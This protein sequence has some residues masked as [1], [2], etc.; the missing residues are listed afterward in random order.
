MPTS[1]YAPV[2]LGQG[3]VLL[4]NERSGGQMVTAQRVA[5][6]LPGCTAFRTLEGHARAICATSPELNDPA[7]VVGA[8]QMLRDA[9]VLT[10][11]DSICRRL[12]G[13]SAGTAAVAP[14]RVFVITC[15][16]P[17]AVERLLDSMLRAGNLSSHEELFLVDDSRDGERAER[18]RSA[19]ENFNLTSSREIRYFGRPQQEAFVQALVEELPEHERGIRFLVDAAEW[20]D[21]W[22]A[23]LARTLCILLSVG[24]R[25]VVVD[26]DVL[27][28]AV[29]SPVQ[30]AGV[31]IGDAARDAAF[32]ASPQEIQARTRRAGLRSAERHRA[33]P[34]HECRAGGARTDRRRP[35]GAEPAR[36][37]RRVVVPLEWRFTRCSNPMRFSGR[38]GHARLPLDGTA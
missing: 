22:S 7:K 26:D 12:A 32:Y 30:E 31:G 13:D 15:D 17:E 36:Y 27:C 33:L 34:R 29:H 2:P 25:A 37:Q 38:S 23:G 5:D 20:R 9:D 11:A 1:A 14:T 18:N 24:R 3:K 6:K 16:R 28:S 10:S 8:L 19:V 4:I 21:Q 35:G